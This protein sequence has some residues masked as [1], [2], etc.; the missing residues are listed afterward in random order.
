MRRLRRRPFCRLELQIH[1]PRRRAKTRMRETH[2]EIPP[3]GEV[4]APASHHTAPR[5]HG[6]TRCQT[7]ALERPETSFQ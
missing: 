3:T 5:I 2:R 1:R 6:N 7:P 4:T